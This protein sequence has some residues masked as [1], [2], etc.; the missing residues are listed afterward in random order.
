MNSITPTTSSS[1]T[2]RRSILLNTLRSSGR[3]S[4]HVWN[5][6]WLG[7]HGSKWPD[8]DR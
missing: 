1:N 2:H 6:Q 7:L 8:Q 5:V 3:L 4:I